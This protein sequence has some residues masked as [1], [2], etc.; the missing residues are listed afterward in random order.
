MSQ[1]SDN[2][3]RKALNQRA[4]RARQKDGTRALRIDAPKDV[5]DAFI[6][7]GWL[8]PEDAEDGLKVR[9]AVEELLDCWVNETLTTGPIVTR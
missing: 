8:R 5:V 1:S 6:A 4:F 9:E 2:P 7:R 3:S